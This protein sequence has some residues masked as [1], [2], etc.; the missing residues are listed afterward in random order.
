[1]NMRR[2]Q[3]APPIDW[4][5]DNADGPL[6]GP[7]A[8]AFLRGRHL[9]LH[10]KAGQQ[11]LLLGEG[12]LQAVLGP[13]RHGMDIGD[14]FGDVDERWQLLFL[15]APDGLSMRWTTDAPLRCGDTGQWQL[16]GGCRLDVVDASAF[17]GTFLAG[18]QAVDPAFVLLLVAR[19]AQAAIAGRLL[20]PA[21]GTGVATEAALQARLTGLRAQDLAEELAPCGLACRE[22][23][24]Y[25]AAAPVDHDTRRHDSAPA[26]GVANG[27]ALPMSGHSD[28]LR[29]D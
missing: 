9:S 23:A 11:A 4:S 10:L 7:L 28:H 3:P 15:C 19:L 17:H 14:R 5:V 12:R 26:G 1:M 13:G 6:Q 18:V 8:L 16:I 27:T 2:H 22:L 20:P 21:P 25:T 24:V 29:R